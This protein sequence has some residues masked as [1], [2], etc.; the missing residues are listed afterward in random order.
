MT[1]LQSNELNLSLDLESLQLL[2]TFLVYSMQRKEFGVT[3][4]ESTNASSKTGWLLWLERN[5]P[6]G[7][8][9]EP[10]VSWTSLHYLSSRYYHH[11]QSQFMLLGAS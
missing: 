6:G 3:D 1:I 5:G 8:V 11:L 7:M 4:D 9:F 10:P 2:Y